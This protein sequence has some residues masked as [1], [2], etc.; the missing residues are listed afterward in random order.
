MAHLFMLGSNVSP[1]FPRPPGIFRWLT[2]M[3]CPLGA[4]GL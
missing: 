1:D 4:L 2:L 3:R